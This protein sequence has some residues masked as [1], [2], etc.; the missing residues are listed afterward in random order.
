MKALF[1]CAILVAALVAGGQTGYVSGGL[2]REEAHRLALLPLQCMQS[3]YPNKLGQTLSGP[4]G[5]QEP[6]LLHPAFFGCFDWHSSVHGH[7]MLVKLLK[8]FPE[9][10]QDLHIKEKLV[11]SL[12]YENMLKE[13]AYFDL[14]QEKSWER[15]YGWAW[16]L[17][18]ATELNTWDDPL[19]RSL[20]SNLRPLTDKIVALYLDFLPQLM[21]PVRVGEHPNTAFGLAFAWDYALATG[22]DSLKNLTESRARN[23]FAGDEN[24]PLAWE[25]GGTDFFSPCLEEA[26]LLRRVLPETEFKS[27]LGRF[28]PL[29]SDPGFK[30]AP[31][32]VSDRSD[33]KLVHLDGLNFSRARC[34]NGIAASLP[35]YGHLRA[36][37]LDHILASLPHITDGNYEGEHWLATFAL[38][39]LTSTE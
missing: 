21:Y 27:W 4:S 18:L 30:L 38:L 29:L 24:C 13:A 32:R 33:G 8:V 19:S 35:E 39:A 36:I 5:L 7:W 2:T 26:D 3:E 25:P 15:T 22:N 14:P 23:F 9:M 16:L 6:H 1:C 34:L 31:G 11:R 37:A 28:L 20:E 10:D 17:K 12:T